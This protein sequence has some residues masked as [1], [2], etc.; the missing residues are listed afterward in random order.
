[1]RGFYLHLHETREVKWFT[2]SQ[3]GEKVQLVGMIILHNK[4]GQHSADLGR[5]AVSTVTWRQTALVNH[6]LRL[7]W[8]GPRVQLEFAQ[9]FGHSNWVFSPHTVSCK[10]KNIL[11][12]TIQRKATKPGELFGSHRSQRRLSK[13]RDSSPPMQGRSFSPGGPPASI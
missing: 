1:M 11:K 4:S 8:R 3:F 6:P 12:P 9:L 10:I 2:K 13:Q 5:E 7:V